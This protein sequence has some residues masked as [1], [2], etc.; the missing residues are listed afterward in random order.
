MGCCSDRQLHVAEDPGSCVAS[1]SN[2][3]V[4]VFLKVLIVE[5]RRRGSLQWPGLCQS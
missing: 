2:T 4:L 3:D 5:L 1:V